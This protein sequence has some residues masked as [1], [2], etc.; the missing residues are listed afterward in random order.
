MLR[1]LLV[2]FGGVAFFCLFWPVALLL[3]L[4][5]PLVWLSLLPLVLI[6]TVFGGIYGLAQL[7]VLLPVR[8]LSDRR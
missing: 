3:L 1:L 4:V 8:A 6:G 5:S 7:L 2:V